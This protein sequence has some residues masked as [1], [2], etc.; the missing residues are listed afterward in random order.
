MCARQL[1]VE[2]GRTT[3]QIRPTARSSSRNAG[4]GP[5]SPHP[6]GVE[7]PSQASVLMSNPSLHFRLVPHFH[8][9]RRFFA[10]FGRPIAELPVGGH[11]PG[12]RRSSDCLAILSEAG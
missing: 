4:G 5:G 2:S 10:P 6:A 11:W 8:T 9:P 1:R 7:A 12:Q 3:E